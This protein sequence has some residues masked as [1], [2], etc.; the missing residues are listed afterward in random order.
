MEFKKTTPEELLGP[1]NEVERKNAP[2]SEAAQI[3]SPLARAFYAGPYGPS[4]SD[5]S[6]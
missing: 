6:D 5:C 4:T 3:K 1:L 2:R